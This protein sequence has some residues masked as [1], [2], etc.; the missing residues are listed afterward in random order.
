MVEERP[1]ESFTFTS[2]GKCWEAVQE[3]LNQKIGALHF[4]G[5]QGLPPVQIPVSLNGLQMFGFMSPLVIQVEFTTF[6][7]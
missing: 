6:S 1:E 3:K 2:V 4:Q 7:A 5:N